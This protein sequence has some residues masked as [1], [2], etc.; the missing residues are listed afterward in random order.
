VKIY[1]V[2]F[3]LVNAVKH[4][5]YYCGHGCGEHPATDA[6]TIPDEHWSY[7]EN[8][9]DDLDEVADQAVNLLK[10]IR[11]GELIRKVKLWQADEPEWS[12]RSIPQKWFVN[13]QHQYV[14]GRA[15]GVCYHRMNDG[16]ICGGHEGA[17]IHNV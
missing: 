9:S 1:K 17:E 14:A 7:V 10:Q 12:E 6:S 13:V 15:P 2:S 5:D 16:A 11:D 4:P 3:E 8:R